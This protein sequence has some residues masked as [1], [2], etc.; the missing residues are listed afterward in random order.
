MPIDI[1]KFLPHREPM[2]MVDEISHLT[3]DEIITSLKINTDNIFIENG[4]FNETG[5]IENAAQTSSGIIGGTYFDLNEGDET[6]KIHGYISKIKRVDIFSL[7]KVNSSIET[8]SKLISSYP[9]EGFL[10]CDMVSETFC[11]EKKIAASSL[12]LIIY[13]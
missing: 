7:P 1:R 6:Y 5:I 10:N 11:D 2:L 9:G 13:V 12:N 8:R 4:F 3:V